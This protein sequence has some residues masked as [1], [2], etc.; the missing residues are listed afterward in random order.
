MIS[1]RKVVMGLSVCFIASAGHAQV[2][3]NMLSF[4]N[5]NSDRYFRFNYENDVFQAIDEYYTQ[6]VHIEIV[7]PGLKKNPLT[8]LLLLP[9]FSIKKY[10]LGIEH[11]GYTPSSIS[12]DNILFGD[13]PF[14]ACLALKSFAIAIDPVH[15]QRFSTTLTTGVIGGAAGAKEM[16]VSIHRWLNNVTPHGWQFQLH[17]D[18]IFNYQIDYE[19]QLFS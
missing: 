14:A 18:A 9:G 13:R 11:D 16:Q 3:D 6:G 17:D 2:I 4:K 15:K 19:K 7:S 12:Y 5:I 8:K 1:W 10:G